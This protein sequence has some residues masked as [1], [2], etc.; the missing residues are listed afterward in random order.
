MSDFE[1]IYS[2]SLVL[3]RASDLFNTFITLLFAFLVAGYLA[4]GTMTKNM[5]RVAIAVYSLIQLLLAYQIFS[6]NLSI[7][8]ILFIMQERK[9]GGSV[10]FDFSSG[11]YASRPSLLVFGGLYMATVFVSFFASVWFFHARGKQ[12]REGS[13]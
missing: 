13:S 6:S 10:A 11:I 7:A 12:V 2:L 3:D 8:K 9:A 5:S 4:S 1:I